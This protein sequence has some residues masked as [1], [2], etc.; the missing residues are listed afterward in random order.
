MIYKASS[1]ALLR[2]TSTRIY[3][4]GPQPINRVC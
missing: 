3:F 4:P 1:L 2:I